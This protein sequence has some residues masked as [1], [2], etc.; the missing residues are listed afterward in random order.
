MEWGTQGGTPGPGPHWVSEADFRVFPQPQE[1]ES[2]AWN[3]VELQPE[4]LNVKN[5]KENSNNSVKK[6]YVLYANEVVC[7][8]FPG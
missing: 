5:F 6:F 1:T 7:M 3:I 4:P 2:H 8:H